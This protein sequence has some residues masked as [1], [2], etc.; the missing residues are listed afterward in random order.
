M[1]ILPGTGGI[2]WG[3]LEDHF[4]NFEAWASL[5]GLGGSVGDHFGKFEAWDPHLGLGDHWGIT[6]VTSRPGSPAWDWGDH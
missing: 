2:T 1:G 6:L 5:V 3:S 4:G